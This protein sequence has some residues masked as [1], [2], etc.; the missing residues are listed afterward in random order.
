MTRD[1]ALKLNRAE[2]YQHVQKV[3]RTKQ[4]RNS[5]ETIDDRYAIYVRCVTDLGQPVK[6]YEQWLRN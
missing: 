1:Q 3:V 6:T 2:W 4:E 5:E